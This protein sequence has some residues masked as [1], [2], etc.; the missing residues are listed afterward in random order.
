MN[1]TSTGRY[2]SHK[3]LLVIVS[4]LRIISPWSQIFYSNSAIMYVSPSTIVCSNGGVEFSGGELINHG[5]FRITKS[6]N[7]PNAGDFK[8]SDSN[9]T[10]GNGLFQVEQDWINNADFLRLGKFGGSGAANGEEA[11]TERTLEVGGGS[12]CGWKGYVGGA[13][14]GAGR[15]IIWY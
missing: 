14:G 7:L 9:L 12:G 10:Y 13:A 2:Y 6:S 4:L 1:S 15:V 11:T 3:K 5:K 8:M